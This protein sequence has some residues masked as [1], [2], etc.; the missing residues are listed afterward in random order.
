MGVDVIAV[1]A[2]LDEAEGVVLLDLLHRAAG[3]IVIVFQRAMCKSPD[4]DELRRQ[5]GILKEMLPV[6]SAYDG[7]WVSDPLFELMR[8]Y[9]EKAGVKT[10]A[11][12]WAVRAAVARQAVTPGGATELMEVLGRE[13]SLE[14]IALAVSELEAG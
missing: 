1:L 5:L 8:G 6:L 12:A 4:A 10:G 7:D 14:R 11:V 2:V 9:A 3:R 13:R